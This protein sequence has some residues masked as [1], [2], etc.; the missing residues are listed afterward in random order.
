MQ[1]KAALHKQLRAT[2]PSLTPLIVKLLIKR[3][4]VKVHNNNN[5]ETRTKE[6]LKPKGMLTSLLCSN[7]TPQKER[8]TCARPAEYT[9]HKLFLPLIN[10]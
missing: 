6:P 8:T 1:M 7:G 3:R 4:R 2:W 10:I 5:T 9:R